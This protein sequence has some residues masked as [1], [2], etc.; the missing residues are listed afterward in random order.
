MGARRVLADLVS[1]VRH[2]VELDDELVPY[3]DLVRRRYEDWLAA[4]AAAGRTF[5]EQQ[6]WWLDQIA[7][8]I[9]VNLGVTA[10]DFGYG[11]L[12]QRG[13]WI[14]ARRLFGPNLPALLEELNEALTL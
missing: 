13:G 1:L 12:F 8:H 9:G 3:P 4:Q 5:S 2:A 10:D 14:A 7:A 11:E 6:R